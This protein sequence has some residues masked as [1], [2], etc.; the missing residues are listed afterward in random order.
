MK[1]DIKRCE[2]GRSNV[3]DESKGLRGQRIATRTM[4]PCLQTGQSFQE[5]SFGRE[6]EEVCG[7]VP[8]EVA[9][10]CVSTLDRMSE[11]EAARFRL[12][13]NP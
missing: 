13:R 12:A 9:A 2:K 3:H 6:S 1:Q 11:R 10:I 4:L 5:S 7:I 8:E